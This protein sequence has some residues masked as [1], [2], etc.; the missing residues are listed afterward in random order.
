M[1]P[2][3]ARRRA[4]LISL[5]FA[6]LGLVAF[7]MLLHDGVLGGLTRDSAVKLVSAMV[8]AGGF[9]ALIFGVAAKKSSL[10]EQLKAS[11][12]EDPDKPWLKRPDWAAGR[13]KS[14]GIPEARSYLV[15]GI[16]LCALGALIATLT[17]RV[18]L[19]TGNYSDLV[20]LLFPVVG[21]A[22]L[23]SILR[24]I[25]AHRQFGDCF[26][27]MAHVPAVPGGV[28]QG[29]F[30]T[31]LPLPPGTNLAFR[32]FCVRRIVAGAGQHRRAD[33]KILWEDQQTARSPGETVP[34][35][36]EIAVLF[37]LPP[38]KPQCSR[39]GGETVV[40]RLE[41]GISAVNF[42]ATF[43]VPVF[44]DPGSPAVGGKTA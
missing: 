20:G 15:M 36:A 7:A 33:E 10:A 40:W 6:A 16:V 35:G 30:C 3:T 26:F 11:L 2:K 17:T 14:A 31:A 19:R 12:L 44:Q 38:N 39:I 24:K 41:V 21:I 5:P 25:H 8:V 32:L 28:L 27:E 1:D 22:F 13:I 18:A 4:A 23:I 9:V 34:A 43:E 42:H 37:D 29:L